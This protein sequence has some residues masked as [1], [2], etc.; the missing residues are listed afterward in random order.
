VAAFGK[1]VANAGNDDHPFRFL[2][3]FLLTTPNTIR[4]NATSL[5]T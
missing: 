5:N 2:A 1:S 3:L 4:M